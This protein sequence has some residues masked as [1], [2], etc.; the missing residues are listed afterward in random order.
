[1]HPESKVVTDIWK[2]KVEQY[3]GPFS[4][5]LHGG[6]R[7]GNGCGMKRSW[8]HLHWKLQKRKKEVTG[9]CLANSQVNDPY[10]TG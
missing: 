5:F 1:M 7:R 3:L 6:K 9:E 4:T 2:K 8:V 10:I